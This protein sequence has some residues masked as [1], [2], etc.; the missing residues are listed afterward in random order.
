MLFF[1]PSKTQWA[2]NFFFLHFF[3]IISLKSLSVHSL[4]AVY[5]SFF[6]FFLSFSLSRS[7]S[8]SIS[9]LNNFSSSSPI[10]LTATQK[11]AINEKQEKKN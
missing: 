1:S 6:A 7:Y 5:E 10:V 8:Y 9:R 3:I 2:R 4:V 11:S